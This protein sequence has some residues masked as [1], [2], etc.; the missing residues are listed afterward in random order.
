MKV[1]FE[2]IKEYFDEEL[3]LNDV[4]DKL[5]ISGTK[6]EN[7]ESNKIEVKNIVTGLIEEIKP[8]PDAEKLV[9]CSVNIGESYVQIVTG[10]KEYEGRRYC[11]CCIAWGDFSRWY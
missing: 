6:V 4:C 2:W 9:V 11:T 1:S 5:T 7:V 8:H 3:K 10:A